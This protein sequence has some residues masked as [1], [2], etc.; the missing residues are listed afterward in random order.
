LNQIFPHQALA[1]LLGRVWV[2][3]V[4]GALEGCVPE[5]ATRNGFDLNKTQA[6]WTRDVERHFSL[7]T[8]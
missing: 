6:M 8:H 4:A 1:F 7:L 2:D 3:L 5:D